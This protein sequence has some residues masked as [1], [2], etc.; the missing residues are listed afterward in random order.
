[1]SSSLTGG[2]ISPAAITHHLRQEAL[3]K[4]EGFDLDVLEL[5]VAA[6]RGG[7]REGRRRPDPSL[8]FHGMMS[9]Y[10]GW[11]FLSL[12]FQDGDFHLPVAENVIR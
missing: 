11:E 8:G 6:G 2:E 4:G 9:R 1:L 5:L 3:R 12:G 7:R 10:D